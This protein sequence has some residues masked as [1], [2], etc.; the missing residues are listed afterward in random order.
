MLSLQFKE[1]NTFVTWSQQT[2]TFTQVAQ[3][4][5]VQYTK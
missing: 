2:T 3:D 4:L 1:V 5:L